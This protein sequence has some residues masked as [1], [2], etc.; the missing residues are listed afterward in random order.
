MDTLSLPWGS[1][2]PAA[3][4]TFRFLQM[5]EGDLSSGTRAK[6]QVSDKPNLPDIST[7]VI[8]GMCGGIPG[9]S[10]FEGTR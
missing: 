9:S 2:V 6:S 7:L 3:C 5:L 1:H 10:I 4:G 8:L